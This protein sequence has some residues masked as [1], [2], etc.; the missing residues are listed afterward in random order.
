MDLH[1]TMG[2]RACSGKRVGGIIVGLLGAG[3]GWGV[4]CHQVV[5]A[6]SPPTRDKAPDKAEQ[7]V[8][9]GQPK[10][11]AQTPGDARRAL[12][13]ARFTG[14]TITLGE[15]EDAIANKSPATR[16]RLAQP[17]AQA[18]LLRRMVDYELLIREAERRGYG[19]DTVVKE[20]GGRLAIDAM[21]QRDFA[22]DPASVSE[23]QV[24]ARYAAERESLSTPRRRRASLVVLASKA[25]ALKLK[26][27]LTGKGRQAFQRAARRDS[28]DERTR[29][30]GGRLGYFDQQGRATP[31]SPAWQVEKEIVT[32][33]Y[34]TAK[35]EISEPFAFGP[36]YGLVHV[37]A[38]QRATSQTLEAAAPAL[39]EALAT[40][41][42]AAAVEA[43][44]QRLSEA[45][46]AQLQ[47]QLL[48][49]IE[50]DAE[51][52]RGIPAGSPAAPADPRAP[53][54]Y[55]EPDGV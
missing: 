38:E 14:G 11:S 52:G 21:V 13:V 4:T 29:Q 30:Q 22:L 55:V 54:V 34:A 10:A 51:A 17:E 48:Q 45:L 23:E 25:E 1:T 43:L 8:E 37:S 24:R 35:G 5:R 26:Q 44:Q 19:Q 46:P 20:R 32:A 16:Q 28:I 42:R 39:R 53:A 31:T 18:E 49:H 47:P 12:V 7:T 27:Q 9:Q 50:V 41:A 6:D 2:Q 3:I 40:E 36:G 33:T 15:L